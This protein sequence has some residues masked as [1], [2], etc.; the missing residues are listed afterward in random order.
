MA[1][2]ALIHAGSDDAFIA[3]QSGFIPDC[4]GFALYRRIKRG[5]Q[6]PPSPNTV[7]QPDAQGFV[8]EVVASWVG[9]AN[10]PDVPPGTREP[11]TTWRIQKYLWSDFAVRSG[12]TVSYRVVP[13]VG[14]R[15]PLQG[16]TT[17]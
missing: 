6:S 4:R 8:E 15:N 14:P 5:P 11:T 10:G 9:F 16:R 7:A 13:M 2:H 1:I 12:N 17:L 3:W